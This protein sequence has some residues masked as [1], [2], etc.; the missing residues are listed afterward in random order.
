MHRQER[1]G[2]ILIVLAIIGYSCL[3]VFTKKLFTRGV[4]PLDIAFWR[5][6]LAGL[7]YWILVFVRR[8][9][10]NETVSKPLPRLKLMA[11]GLLFAGEAVA[12]FFGWERLPAG[13]FVVLFYSYPA[14]VAILEAL[15]GERLSALAW[16]ALVLTLIGIALTAPDFSAGLTGGNFVGVMLALFDGLQVAIYFLVSARVMRG[17]SDMVGMSAWTVTGALIA[18][19]LLA[20]SHGMALPQGESWL[21]LIAIALVSTV[22]PVFALNA[23]IQKLGAT[24]S[25]II[26]TFEPLLTAVLALVFLGEM[27]LPIQWLGGVVIIA[28]VILLQLRRPVSEDAEQTALARE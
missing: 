6:A 10:P 11:L 12:A 8:R 7:I 19:T 18:V 3:S 14:M 17:Y 21:Y 27:M 25:A 20:V 9:R 26:A 2:V 4:E 5:F 22:L 16:I 23:G 13:T 1:D 28:S 24:R 15:L